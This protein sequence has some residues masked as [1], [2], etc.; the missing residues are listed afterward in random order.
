MLYFDLILY[1]WLAVLVH[2]TYDGMGQWDDNQLVCG[3]ELVGQ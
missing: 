3:G 2:I 1:V